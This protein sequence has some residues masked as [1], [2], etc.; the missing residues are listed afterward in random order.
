[1][2]RYIDI[3]SMTYGELKIY[4]AHRRATEVV[5]RWA[6]EALITGRKISARAVLLK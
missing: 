5:D 2:R 3:D 6:E 4:Y 1:M